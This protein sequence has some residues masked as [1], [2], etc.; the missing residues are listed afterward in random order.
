M[1]IL[2]E[3][4]SRSR[5]R[6]VSGVDLALIYAALGN[7]DEAFEWL[8][9]AYGQ[10]AIDLIL[11]KDPTWDSL[12]PDPRYADLLRRIGFPES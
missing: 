5:E 4:E 7:H 2:E 11:L 1:A 12:R 6:Y 8:E 9:K 10:Q 3:L